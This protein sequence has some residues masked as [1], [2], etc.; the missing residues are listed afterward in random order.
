M[1]ITFDNAAPSQSVDFSKTNTQIAR[2][3]VNNR[4]VSGGVSPSFAMPAEY[5]GKGKT[6]ADIADVAKD[7]DVTNM[8]NAMTV[9]ANTMSEKDFSKAM[10]DGVDMSDV[11]V[12]DS[13]TIL[14]RIKLEVAK[15]GTEIEGFTDDIDKEALKEMTG[16]YDI[17]VSDDMAKE[18]D[19][20]LKM[21][22]NVTEMTDEMKKHFVI[23]EDELTIDNLFI[24]KYS[25]ADN[26][27]SSQGKYF[28]LENSAYLAVKGDEKDYKDL[29][30]QVENLL[31]DLDIEI[32]EENLSASKWLIGNYLEVSKDSIDMYKRVESLEL[33]LKDEDLYRSIYIAI[34]EG[35]LPK[36]AVIDAKE[37]I[38]EKAIR[39]TD[40]IEDTFKSKDIDSLIKDY[41]NEGFDVIH[42]RRVLE[43][44]RL[45]MTTEANLLLLKSGFSIDTSEMSQY[46]DA[47]VKLE[48]SIT[49]KEASM[50]SEV[51]ETFEEIKALPAMVV[52]FV[53]RYP[54]ADMQAIKDEGNRLKSDYE[55]AALTYEA[56]GTE[57][58]RDLGD[59]IKKAFRNVD[60]LINETGLEVND[61]TR[62]ATRILG[63][64]RMEVTREN[65]NRIAEADSKLE[66]VLNKLSPKDTLD[67]IRK[68]S[69][70]V[71][72]TV[73]E[74]NDY[75]NN[76]DSS[77]EKEMEK[78]SK[79]LYKLEKNNEITAE[80][81]AAYIDV[82][83]LLHAIKK[84]DYAAIGAVV[85]AG[86]QLSFANLKQAVLS[87]KH[88]GMDV[89]I[90]ES[91]GLLVDK[92][93]DEI[94]PDRLKAVSFDENNTLSGL[95]DDITKV[96]M[97][98]E[99]QMQYVKELHMQYKEAMQSPVEV[100]EELVNNGEVVSQDTL[101][102]A[103]R[104]MKKAKSTAEKLDEV[105]GGELKEKSN[106]LVESLAGSDEAK[107]SMDE[108]TTE[109][110][111]KIFNEAMASDSY[112]D[113][114]ELSLLHKQ[115]TLVRNYSENEY[116]KIPVE[117]D[118]EKT[119]ASVRFV[120]DGSEEPGIVISLES[121]NLGRVSSRLSISHGKTNG[122]IATNLKEAVEKLKKVSDKLSDDVSVV[123][124]KDC[125]S[126]KVLSQIHM[127]DNK[128]AET[129]DLY[130][131][132][133]TFLNALST[134]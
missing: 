91:F 68:G 89:K 52:D 110:K 50:V 5:E 40:E 112:I 6:K 41:A 10:E 77:P 100:V 51:Y 58:R 83:R 117:I 70:P 93:E 118:G 120:H 66:A 33:P 65:I 1:K 49:Y 32:N 122:Y 24:A 132:A 39:L 3:K 134:I 55:A 133:E 63:Y 128:E 119:L 95:Y 97:D 18:I 69:S 81:R 7:M 71:N 27:T 92:L 44:V 12:E 37:S 101:L 48:E 57:V 121:E 29:D 73:D 59:S 127:K 114:R 116:Y 107:E 47:L 35:K 22:S 96:P 20:A 56:V 43:Q 123:Y 30:K 124:S 28:T 74:L 36:D 75:I 53:S 23:S 76:R 62:R 102:A 111:E 15:G 105:D 126:D 87:G 11:S 79:Y 13:V 84:G 34:S 64:N 4:Q 2:E 88:S 98:K 115:M 129:K 85:N 60:E 94:T 106:K 78:Y 42:A 46:V 17:D 21:A 16:R 72:M 103:S 108:V 80:E 31:E 61:I 125:D 86:Q 14:D 9:M 104:L 90:D 38:Y 8:Q 109:L 113:V 26:S 54:D 19:E 131:V 45:S 130:K 25:V 67:I 82:Y 99:Y